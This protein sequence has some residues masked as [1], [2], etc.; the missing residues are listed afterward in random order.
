PSVRPCSRFRVVGSIRRPCA[1]GSE[2]SRRAGRMLAALPHWAWRPHG[3][4]VTPVW[5]R[6]DD[7]HRLGLVRRGR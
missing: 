7:A 3:T 6:L 2:R 1:N 5:G 4:T